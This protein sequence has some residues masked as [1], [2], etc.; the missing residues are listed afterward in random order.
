ML[1]TATCGVLS[2]VPSALEHNALTPDMLPSRPQ[3]G[4]HR[5]L[6]GP[7]LENA[8]RSVLQPHAEEDGRV[9]WDPPLLSPGWWTSPDLGATPPNCDDPNLHYFHLTGPFG[10]R[11][12]NALIAIAKAVRFVVTHERQPAALMQCA[13]PK[14]RVWTRWRSCRT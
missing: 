1:S 11:A 6:V 14:R 10:G 8:S 4:H 2:A 13:C 7:A 3:S 12:N 9:Q 5:P